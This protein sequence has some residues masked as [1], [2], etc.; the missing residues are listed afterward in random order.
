MLWRGKAR[1]AAGKAGT[2]PIDK[3]RLA[4]GQHPVGQKQR[5]IGQLDRI[6]QALQQVH[7]PAGEM[8][9]RLLVPAGHHRAGRQP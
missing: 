3:Q 1:R 4:A 2:G 8:L 5:G 9:V 6:G 7:P